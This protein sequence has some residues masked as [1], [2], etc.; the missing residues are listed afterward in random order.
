M[1]RVH[2]LILSTG[3]PHMKFCDLYI[4]QEK[5]TQKKKENKKL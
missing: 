1:K 3:N 2:L 4:I 5:N